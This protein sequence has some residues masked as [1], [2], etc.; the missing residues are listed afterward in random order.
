MKV[1]RSILAV[2]ML[3]ATLPFRGF[4]QM[5]SRCDV[6]GMSGNVIIKDNSIF[7][8]NGTADLLSA[9]KD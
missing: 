3:V 7:N 2:L 1:F 6:Y 5:P 9:R 8:G 4:A